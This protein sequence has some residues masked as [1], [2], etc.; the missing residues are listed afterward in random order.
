[1]SAISLRN[2]KKAYGKNEVVHGVDFEAAAGEFV[3]IL[4][5][6]GC[7]KSTLLRMVAGLES[8]TAGD[9]EIG[10]R[11]VN[12]LEPRERGCAMVFQNYA[13]YPHMSVADNI[14]YSLKVAGVPRSTRETRVKAVAESL[15]LGEFLRRKPGQLSGGQR[16][17]VAMGRAM[18]REPLVFLYDEPLSNLDAKL[19]VAMRVEIR[20]LHQKLGTTTLFVTHDQVEAMT[21]ADRIVVMNKGVIEQVGTPADV[22]H[23]PQSTY[24]ASFIGAP[25]MNILPARLGAGSSLLLLDDGQTVDL[26]GHPGGSDLPNEVH[27]GIR[28]ESISLANHGRGVRAKVHF[29]EEL[30]SSRLLHAEVGSTPIIVSSKDAGIIEPGAEVNLELPPDSLHFFNPDS[31]RRI[32]H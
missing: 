24:V 12:A 27:V 32:A 26:A 28:A 16:Q 10:G 30:G 6:S 11:V 5:P 15:G 22:Y 14:G 23:R 21:L 9:I 29:T 18:I 20:R 17:R 19:R 25:G 2:V 13:L 4:G 1:M 8:V 31:G 7:G 3:V